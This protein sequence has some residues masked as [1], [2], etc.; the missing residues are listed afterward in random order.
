MVR[1]LCGLGLASL[2]MLAACGDDDPMDP[3]GDGGMPDAPPA[4]LTI[5]EPTAPAPP[6]FI[7]CEDGLFA[8]L[9]SGVETCA[10][11]PDQGARECPS[12]QAHFPGDE[13]CTPIVGACSAERFPTIAASETA[14]YV[15]PDA[16]SGGDG[17]RARPFARLAEAIA[18]ARRGTIIALSKGEHEA[19]V[20][21]PAGVT[22]RGAC[23]ETV[24]TAPP[25]DTFESVLGA[26]ADARVER[27]RIARSDRVGVLVQGARSEIELDHVL[28]EETLDAGMV[29]ASSATIVARNVVVRRVRAS[30]EES[31]QG[32]VG[33]GGYLELDRV[34]VA[35]NP[36]SGILARGPTGMVT[37][38]H[39]RFVDQGST[40]Y[41]IALRVQ[42]IP[43]RITASSIEG[44]AGAAIR[45]TD[46]TML[47]LDA[48]TIARSHRGVL[49]EL[50]AQAMLRRLSTD[51]VLEAAV[52]V[53]DE[54]S[55]L[56]LEDAVIAGTRID[57]SG[58]L[59]S[60]ALV[61]QQSGH[62]EARRVLIDDC[63]EEPVFI[64][65]GA[66]ATIEDLVVRDVLESG[67]LAA[68]IQ[69]QYDAQL[70]LRRALLQ[71]VHHIAINVGGNATLNATDLVIED[72][73]PESEG[74]TLGRAMNAFEGAIVDIERARF[75]RNRESTVY[76]SGEGT[77]LALRETSLL[78]SEPRQCAATT[79]MDDSGGFGVVSTGNASIELSAFAL[80]GAALCGVLVDE[81]AVLD[82]SHGEVRGAAIGACVQVPDYDVARLTNEVEYRENGT[83]LVS[84]SLPVP[85]VVLG[86]R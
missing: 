15:D 55:N 62:L 2:G 35:D 63:E 24:V 29:A 50:G 49:V 82:L 75:E 61:A 59:R 7:A 54:G 70:E 48:V 11:Y 6:D 43:L 5:A 9:R 77:Q 16:T 1:T 52:L 8:V 25:G 12:L 22:L 32:L 47:D 34:V 33:I 41:H 67:T 79:C 57:P 64:T 84:T 80:R 20:E 39:T 40:K 85:P 68:G 30:V 23:E 46:A 42:E 10:P 60:I 66:T 28:I 3:G 76:A 17:T 51:G 4:A 19:G 18:M 36:A 56:T 83:Q 31:G 69:V 53:M 44:G 45:V 86:F 78:G 74:G 26:L 21:L 38:H 65:H 58:Q 72:T 14:L 71:R 13:G 27:L 73:Q 81:N 37:A